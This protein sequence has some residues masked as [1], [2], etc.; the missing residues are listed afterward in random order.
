MKYG[1]A[2]FVTDEGIRPGPLGA[3]LEERGFDSVFLAEH[4]HIPVSRETPYPGGG[5][6]P[7]IYYRTLDPFVALT[8]AAG[9]TTN[10]LLATGI[11]LVPQRDVIHLAKQ[12]ASLDL[13]SNGRA[14]LGVGSGWNREEMRNHG[15]EPK[16]RGPLMNERLAA[17]K[18]IWTEEQAEFHGE[19]VNFDPIFSWPK[20]V[21]RPHPPIYVGGE[22]PAAL[23]RLLK[24][25]DGWLPRGHMK[26][27]EI[28]RVRQWLADE[29]RPNVPV[30]VFGANA[31]EGTMTG[32]TEAGVERVTFLLATLPEAETLTELDKLAALVG[33]LD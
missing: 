6:L 27:E 19:Y 14:V 16:T 10:L 4:S 1:I 7:R 13:V 8:A 24:Y 30:T 18:K 17:L 33:K 2:T 31:D 11:A 29:G 26:P 12:V 9:T 3:A 28:V 20:P 25:G 15:A 22:T 21:Q 23:D 5:D 32:L